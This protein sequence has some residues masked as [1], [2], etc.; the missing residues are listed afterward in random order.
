MTRPRI[1]RR[2]FLK[3]AVL[4]GSAAL[5]LYANRRYHIALAAEPV[6][7]KLRILHT[8][9]HHS[10][11]EPT[12]VKIHE[13]LDAVTT[14]EF[15][16]VARCKTLLDQIRATAAADENVLLLDAGDI[17]PG[18]LY[19]TQ[20]NGQADLYFY[21]RMGYDAVT[22]GNHEF[23]KGQKPLR[24]FILGAN[25]PVLSANISVQPDA[26]L[27]AALAPSDIA[28]AGK[29]GKRVI[30]SKGGKTI[31]IFGLTPPKTALYSDVGPG[32][33]FSSALTA[34]AQAQVDALKVEG[35]QYIVGLTHV[36]YSVDVQLAAQVRG[37]D[38]IVGGHSHTP[39]LPS[40]NTALLGTTSQGIYPTV[41]KNPEGKNVVVTTAWKWGRWLGDMTLG[42]DATG[43]IAEVNGEIRPVWANGLG[44]PPRALRAGEAAEIAPDA[45]FQ[46]QIDTVYKP[47][48]SQ[49]EAQI[50]GQAAI[51]LEG[52]R[53][54]IRNRETNLGNFVADVMLQKI[55][56]DG[57]QMTLVNSGQFS[58]TIPVGNISLARVIQTLPFDNTIAVAD[59]TGAQVWA[60]LENAVSLMDFK[61]PNNSSGRFA[62]VSGLQF[63]WSPNRPLGQR[64]LA[65]KVKSASEA[66]PALVPLDLNA[67]YR[68]VTNNFVLGGGDGFSIFTQAQNQTDTGILLVDMLTEYLAAHSPVSARVE[69]RI[70][71]DNAI[72]LPAIFK[73]HP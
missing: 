55:R 27:A 66:E 22:V 17:F 47:P 19:F 48:L 49:L 50:V 24:D 21:N 54:D 62:Q 16:G 34:T 58:R 60:A 51:S 37:M 64:I 25:F 5:Y 31:G 4:S 2:H 35:A 65:V 7:Y 26:T 61:N 38:V 52:D 20:Y 46:A 29:L 42:F 18:T 14:R 71:R 11:I 72:F 9:D 73:A 12:V 68:V 36:G 33:S 32:V 69:G 67:T 43:A 30:V 15:G 1:N 40:L 39:L 63:W 3:R 70:I 8:N 56:P 13:E 28:V 10:W 57:A 41:I 23:D 6:V 59:L 53:K 45:A 44:S